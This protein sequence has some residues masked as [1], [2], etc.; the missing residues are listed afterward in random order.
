LFQGRTATKRHMRFIKA[1]TTIE[2]QIA[3]LRERG[4]EIASEELARRWLMTVGYYRLSAYWLPFE[5][6]P[7]VGQTR[8]KQFRQGVSFEEVVDIYTFDRKLR[9]LV[10][11]AIERIEISVR[12]RWT[13]RLTLKDGAHAH[14]NPELFVSGW[15]HARMIA[16]LAD[17]TSESREVSIEHYREK[18]SAPYMPPLWAITELMT[19]GELSKW[20]EATDDA[21]LRSAVA[22][23]IGLPTQETLTGTL[24]LLS[25]TRNI[26][27][28][29]GRLWNRKT[30]KRAPN[31]KRFRD[32]LTWDEEAAEGQLQLSNRIYNVLTLLVLLMRHQASDTTFPERLRSIIE[33][34]KEEQKA[35]MGFPGDWSTRPAWVLL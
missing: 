33:A 27:A 32:S 13:N 17:R 18:Y 12:S 22:R 23:D 29:H 25:Y 28:H 5:K 10:T 26:C 21:R 34:R 24:Q 19:F 8:S 16:A 31:I 7:E 15:K 1:P 3:L 35:A 14:M 9:L 4:L 6:V 20:V 11:E 30:V 2:E